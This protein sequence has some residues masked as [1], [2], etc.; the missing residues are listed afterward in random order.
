M[1]LTLPIPEEKS[2]KKLSLY[3]CVEEFL[4]EEKLEKDE[5]W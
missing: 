2:K 5:K 4:A 3:D 1:Y